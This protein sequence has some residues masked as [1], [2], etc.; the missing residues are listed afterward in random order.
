MAELQP[1]RPKDLLR[2]VTCGSVDDGKSTLLGRLL[3]DCGLVPDDQLE[4]LAADSRRFGTQGE[5]LDFALLLD[6]L[7]AEREQGITI[8][9]AYRFFATEARSFIVA[10]APG[11]EQYTRNL[12]TGASTA[13]LAVLLVDVRKGLQAQTRRHAFLAHLLGIREFVLAVNKMDLVDYDRRSFEAIAADFRAFA[14]RLYLGMVTAIP[15]SALRGDNIVER[16]RAMRWYRGPTLVEHLERL[17]LEGAALAQEP[18]RLP[19]QWVSRTPDFR[20]YCG[21]IAAGTAKAGDRVR[22]LPSG[23]ESRIQ[24]VVA[25]DGERE[26]AAAGESVTLTLEDEVDCARGDIIASLDAPLEVADQFE[27]DLV[28]MDEEELRPGRA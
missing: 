9:V 7:S 4:A 12:V 17:P 18:L 27:A 15:L 13:E 6:G 25:P 19:V 10:D 22:I 8:D 2:F 24:R 14:D 3:H 21:L 26:G 20:G 23:R 28:W 16:S 11:H 5:A 1:D